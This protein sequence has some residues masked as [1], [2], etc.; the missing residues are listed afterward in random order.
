MGQSRPKR[1]TPSPEGCEAK[2][3][4]EV[5]SRAF[6]GPLRAGERLSTFNEVTQAL[7]SFRDHNRRPAR[8][9]Q[10][11][12]GATATRAAH[13]EVPPK[14]APWT[15][16]QARQRVLRRRQL[17]HSPLQTNS[18]LAERRRR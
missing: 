8:S 15:L 5:P 9:R 13:E 17:R 11:A 3:A 2:G 1:R 16:G 4:Q 10:L 18:T 14:T 7:T 12:N 6:K